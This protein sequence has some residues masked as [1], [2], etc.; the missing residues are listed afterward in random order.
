MIRGNCETLFYTKK[1]NFTLK[2][3]HSISRK[4]ALIT[5]ELVS[6]I[7]IS[8]RGESRMCERRISEAT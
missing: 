4:K 7:Y 1:Y 3:W 2:Y 5:N 6:G 8:V